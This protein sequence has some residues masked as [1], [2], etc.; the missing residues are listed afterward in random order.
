MLESA[1]AVMGPEPEEMG[2]VKNLFWGEIREDLIFPYPEVSEEET[3]KADEAAREKLDD[4][5]ENEHPAIRIDREQEIPRSAIDRLFEIGVMGMT[6]PEKFGGLGLGHH[7]LQPGSGTPRPDLCLDLGGRFR[8]PVD[9]LQG[10]DAVW[11]RSA[12]KKWLPIMARSALSAF[13]LVRA[14]RG[15]RRRRTGNP[16]GT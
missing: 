14:Q 8:P 5:L 1:Q 11:N 6:I 16:G 2:F 15:L 13:C 4:Y 10:G 9:R 7:Q 12:K 3:R